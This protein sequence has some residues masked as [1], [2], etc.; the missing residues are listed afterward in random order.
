[1]DDVPRKKI[2]TV[3]YM[4]ESVPVI[5]PEPSIILDWFNRPKDGHR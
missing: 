4:T 1:M 2:A 5:T 3:Y